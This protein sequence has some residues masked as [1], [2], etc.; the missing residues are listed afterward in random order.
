MS[1]ILL[2]HGIAKHVLRKTRAECVKQM[3]IFALFCQI[4][5]ISR[6]K[7]NWSKSFIT[8]DLLQLVKGMF[9][10]VLFFNGCL[11]GGKACDWHAER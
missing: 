3:L 6:N 5:D 8:K 2:A 7:Q 10:Y 9:Y 11:R 1:F 4:L